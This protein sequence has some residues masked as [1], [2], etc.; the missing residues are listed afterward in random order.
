[1]IIDN[2]SVSGFCSGS[3]IYVKTSSARNVFKDYNSVSD[4]ANYTFVA[5]N[6]LNPDQEKTTLI[7][8]WRWCT[9]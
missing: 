8:K 3:S 5:T 9:L 4:L 7:G 2:S 1:E 6:C